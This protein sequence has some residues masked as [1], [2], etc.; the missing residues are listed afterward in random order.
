[1]QSL[2]A[3]GRVQQCLRGHPAKRQENTSMQT[4]S[5]NCRNP[6]CAIERCEI[7]ESDRVRFELHGK[8][9]SGSHLWGRREPADAKSTE[10][11]GFDVLKDL[12]RRLDSGKRRAFHKALPLVKRIRMLAGKVEV[13]DRRSFIAG[14]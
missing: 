1:M 4:R 2:S 11:A 12:L 9:D 6:R 3:E 5:G 13:A 14:D 7:I 10:P 8:Q